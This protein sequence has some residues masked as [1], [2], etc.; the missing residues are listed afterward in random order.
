[1]KIAILDDYQDAVRKLDCFHLLDDHEVKVFNN[2]VRGLGQLASRLSEVDALVLIRERT[3]ISSQLLDKL[4]RLRMISQTGKAGGGHIDIDACT[5][6]GI[7]VLEGTG[8][9]VAPAELTWALIMAAQRRIPQ[10]VANLK[11]GAW[12]QSGLK[13]SALPPNFGLGP[14]AARPDAR[15]LGL[16]QDRPAGRGLRQGVRHE[17]ADLRPRAFAGSRRAKTA[18]TSRR[19]AKRCSNRA[20]C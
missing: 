6:R 19:A 3:R 8:S 11:Q 7:A 10:Y 17:R 12:Q 4:P 9:P 18:T 20:T 14:G 16:R 2:T 15:H 13:T 5:E 1:M